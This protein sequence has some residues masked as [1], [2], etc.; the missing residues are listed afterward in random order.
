MARLREEEEA[1]AYERMMNPPSL[2]ETLNQ[3]FSAWSQPQIPS[4]GPHSKEDEDEVTFADINRQMT[5]IINVLVSIIA[6]SVAIWMAASHWSTPKRLG[7]SMGG[8][9]VVGIAEVV[10]YA[11]YLRRVK[12][13]KD[14]ERKKPETKEII[15][16]WVIESDE[17]GKAEKVS[18]LVEEPTK[19]AAQ[20]RKRSTN[21]KR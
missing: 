11:G 1:L 14:K 2:P 19:N 18:K 3:R 21:K 7:L 5:L 9:G 8:S 10:V 16:T 17:R 20:L 12:E 4:I 13:A 15:G 6:C